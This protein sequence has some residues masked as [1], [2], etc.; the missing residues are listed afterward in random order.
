VTQTPITLRTVILGFLAGRYPAA[1]EAAAVLI[2]VNCC[3]L[4]DK[5]VTKDEVEAELRI[6]ANRMKFVETTIDRTSGT[7]FWTATEDG[8]RQ[9][10]LDGQTY[11][12]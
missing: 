12:S 11:V 4:L 9:W 2:R 8:V 5:R 10:H 1:Y 7:V 3:G 6:L